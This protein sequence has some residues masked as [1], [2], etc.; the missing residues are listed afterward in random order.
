[1]RVVTTLSPAHIIQLHA[2]YTQEWWTKG[3]T[4]EQ[5]EQVVA[6]S[7][8][9]IGVLDDEDRLQAFARVLSDFVFKA[10]LFDVIVASA[11]RGKGVGEQ[12]MDAVYHHPKLREV[13]HFE[14][15]CHPEMANF[16]RRYGFVETDS[17]LQLMRREKDT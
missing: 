1:M 4:L 6:N 11:Y 16:Y 5:T 9:V 15:Y 3:R 10:L 7:S 12:L 2:L 8:V 17:K 13:R 14:L